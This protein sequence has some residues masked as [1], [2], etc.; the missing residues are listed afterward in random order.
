MPSCNFFVSHQTRSRG[1]W[2]SCSCT[3]WF[4][5][6]SPRRPNAQK[7]PL[8]SSWTSSTPRCLSA[9]R[10]TWRS[11]ASLTETPPTLTSWKTGFPELCGNS[12]VSPDSTS[13]PTTPFPTAWNQV[14]QKRWFLPI[15]FLKLFSDFYFMMETFEI[16]TRWCADT[17]RGRNNT[18]RKPQSPGDGLC[19]I[20][21][22][23]M[24]EFKEESAMWSREGG[25]RG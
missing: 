4:Y 10:Q 7:T 20:V 17:R 25:D 16:K 24:R 1:P 3:P 6:T 14:R 11:C 2:R 13:A 12:D 15:C 19:Y 18:Q 9:V 8:G 21:W 23:G 22:W 5:P